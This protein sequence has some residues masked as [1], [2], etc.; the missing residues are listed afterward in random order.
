MVLAPQD[1]QRRVAII[2]TTVQYQ[3][4]CWTNAVLLS[5]AHLRT[6]LSEARI[7][8]CKNSFK[9]LH[10][11]VICEML[12]I[13]SG[14]NVLNIHNYCNVIFQPKGVHRRLYQVHRLA[15]KDPQSETGQGLAVARTSNHGMAEYHYI[16]LSYVA[17]IFKMRV[18]DMYYW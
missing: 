14:L 18:F 8:I 1:A 11:I 2:V 13:F 15:A 12:A 3:G 6:D 7:K 5:M 17:K 10:S 4:I 16:V 9:K